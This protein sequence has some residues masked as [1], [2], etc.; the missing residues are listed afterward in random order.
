MKLKRFIITFIVSAFLFGMY[1]Y[2]DAST[3]DPMNPNLGLNSSQEKQIDKFITK[4]RDYGRIPGVSVVVVSGNES[5]Y[6]KT[7]GFSDIKTGKKVDTKT[8]FELGSTSKAFTALGI[9]RLEKEGKIRLDDPVNKY[10]RGFNM[11]YKGKDVELKISNLLYQT[12][13][14]PFKTIGDIPVSNQEDALEKTVSNLVNKELDFQ[15]GEKFLYATINYDVLG[16]IIEKVSGISYEKYIKENVLM[17]LG[18]NNTYLFADDAGSDMSKGYKVGFTR[19]LKYDAPVYRGDKPAGYIITNINDMENWLKIQLGLIQPASFD[20]TLIEKT[21]IPDMTVLPSPDGSSY[22]MGWQ[23]YP[24]GG[25]EIS[26]GGSNPTFSSFIVFRPQEKLGVAVLANL[27][28][29]Y[30]EAIGKGI[31]NILMGKEEKNSVTDTYINIDNFAFTIICVMVPFVLTMLYFLIL[32]FLQIIKGK[33]RYIGDAKYSFYKL[34]LT[35]AF[36][37]I[38]GFCLYK[39]PD[40]LYS[41]LPWSFVLV[42]AP[43]SFIL[44][45]ILIFAAVSVFSIYYYL[46]SIITSENDKAFFSTATLSVVSG[47]GNALVIFI[48]NEAITRVSE[49][50][51]QDGLF[52]YFIMGITLYIFCQRLVRIKL[53][54]MAN[55]LVYSKRLELIKRILKTSYQSIE[56]LENGNI[57]AGLN[58]DTEVISN[59]VSILISGLTSAVTL[60]CCLIYLGTINF[61]GLLISFLIISLAAG[62]YMIAGRSANKLW[63]Q[64]RDIQNVFFSFINDLVGGFKELSINRKKCNEFQKDMQYSCDEYRKKRIKGDIKF[65]NVFVIGELLFIFAIG[66]VAFF[67]PVIFKNIQN[68][69]LRNYVFVFL[70]MAG[71]VNGL[72]NAIPNIIRVKIS[73]KR[74]NDLIDQLKCEEQETKEELLHTYPDES[75]NL[76][77]NNVT[78]EYKNSNDT[79]F[80]IGPISCSFKSGEIIF[81][82]GGNG[83]GKS[84]FAKILLG[85]YKVDNGSISINGSIMSPAEIGQKYSVVFSDF[86]LFNK[87][88]GIDFEGKSNDINIHLKNLHLD[89]KLD[90][91]DGVFSTLKLST[92]QRKRIALMISYLEDRPIIL[93]DEWAADQDPEFRKYFYEVLLPELKNRGK[94]VIAITHDDRYFYLADKLVKMEMGEVVDI[95]MKKDV[96]AAN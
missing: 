93:F 51:F 7:F 89:N 66:F 37:C 72:L 14:I 82:T 68:N 13:G 67:F 55:N 40:V 65:A 18:M 2:A 17:P 80:K 81:I 61:V 42:W 83:S 31:I 75:I 35:F 15:P 69:T 19:S 20:N 52:I 16:L 44:A 12:S 32:F 60:L 25:G 30:T 26:H 8:E 45:L 59:F 4:Q 9:L 24:K 95:D 33:R 64:T 21:H 74:L 85:L 29:S 92:G 91:N 77:L 54:K 56:S 94:C 76:E 38:A 34:L 78:Y 1:T 22:A 70:Y 10:I 27:N 6:K 96:V 73:W 88:Y 90:I 86:Y 46:T 49:N 3:L 11:R 23:I 47:F 87:L 84:T 41:G 50:K 71:P 53:I 5:I 28:S 57:Q 62:V 48:I 43:Q 58:N 36:I 79:D 39:I 63:E